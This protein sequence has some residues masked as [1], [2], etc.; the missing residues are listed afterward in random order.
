VELSFGGL[1]IAEYFH[2]DNRQH[3][4][5]FIVNQTARRWHF[6]HGLSVTNNVFKSL[7]RRLG[8]V[9]KVGDDSI[10]AVWTAVECER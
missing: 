6:I 1:T 7:D 3:S 8:P 10:A 5:S 4:F 9:E 2:A